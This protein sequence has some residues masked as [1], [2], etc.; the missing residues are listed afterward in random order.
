MS[1]HPA[2]VTDGL[3]TRSQKA[4]RY[5]LLRR[6]AGR[7]SKRALAPGKQPLQAAPGERD[8]KH[9]R[10]EAEQDPTLRLRFPAA[11]GAQADTHWGF[12]LSRGSAQA[13]GWAPPFPAWCHPGRGVGLPTPPCNHG[14][15]PA[16]YS[17]GEKRQQERN[18]NRK[19]KFTRAEHVASSQGGSSR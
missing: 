4:D 1:S 17:G 12:P 6:P 15:H 7:T 14:P 18:K 10:A 16:L 13:G 3:I 8:G 9:V 2:K 5:I 19:R 11:P